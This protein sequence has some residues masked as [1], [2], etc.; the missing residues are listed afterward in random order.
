MAESFPKLL[1]TINLHMLEH[2]QIPG[3]IN[4]KRPTWSLSK[5]SLRHV[6]ELSKAK[7]EERTLEAA[8]GKRIIVNKG[9]LRITTDFS[10]DAIGAK[11]QW[12][13]MSDV[14]KEKDCQLKNSMTGK[15]TVKLKKKYIPR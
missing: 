13:D 1:T 3:E 9:V 5:E 7:D 4:S 8:R 12:D 15:K 14:L 2:W 6:A 10:I 11:R